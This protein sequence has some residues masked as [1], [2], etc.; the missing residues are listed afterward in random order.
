MAAA[1]HLI[2]L[3]FLGQNGKR[4]RRMVWKSWGG[5]AVGSTVCLS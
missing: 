4:A 3:A 2:A 5:A 1:P